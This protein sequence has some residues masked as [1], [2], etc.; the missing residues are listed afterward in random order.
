MAVSL[1]SQPDNPHAGRFD[2]WFAASVPGGTRW[3]LVRY[4][5]LDAVGKPLGAPEVLHS[6]TRPDQ[7][8]AFATEAEATRI[9]RFVNDEQ[10]PANEEATGAATPMAS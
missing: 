2:R 9:A 8:V 7:V 4:P 5:N 1:R 6:N 10:F 3:R